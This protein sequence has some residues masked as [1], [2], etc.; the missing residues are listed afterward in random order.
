MKRLSDP[1]QSAIRAALRAGLVCA[2]AFGLKWTPYQI[3]TVQLAGEALLYA[4]A[5]LANGARRDG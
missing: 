5:Q 3:G 4:Y 1:Q 2:T